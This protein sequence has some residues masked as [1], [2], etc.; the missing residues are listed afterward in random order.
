MAE[1]T[2][3]HQRNKDLCFLGL[4]VATLPNYWLRK[5]IYSLR[6]VNRHPIH[7]HLGC[8]TRYLPGF[9]NIDANPLHK[10]DMWLDVRCGLPL[11]SESVDSIYSTHMAEHFYSDELQKLLAECHRTLKPGAGLRL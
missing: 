9:I 3:L 2:L 1:V 8:G 11:P 7:L 6:P 5:C 4:A 10:L